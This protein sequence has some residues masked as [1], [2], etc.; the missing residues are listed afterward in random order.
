MMILR[1]VL[2]L[3]LFLA[4]QINISRAGII[5]RNNEKVKGGEAHTL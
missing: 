5:Y 3:L 2:L 1:K 4:A